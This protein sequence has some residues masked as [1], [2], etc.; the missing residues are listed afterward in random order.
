MLE[1]ARGKL[2][3]R[4]DLRK[5]DAADLPYRDG[6]FDLV[7]AFLTL[8]EMPAGVRDTAMDE[9][10]RVAGPEGRLLVLDFHTGPLRFPRGW[11]FKTGILLLEMGAGR[12]HF[13][14]YRDFLAR[15]GVRG[16]V[17]RRSLTVVRERVLSGGNV[18]ASVLRP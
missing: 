9:I 1:V 15:R 4:A 17:E 7:V 5:C 6:S 16:L 12:D 8:H 14:N 18:L 11:L 3:D 10:V 2:G 13:R